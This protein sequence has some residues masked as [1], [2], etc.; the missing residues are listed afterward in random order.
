MVN[1]GVIVFDRESVENNGEKFA[2]ESEKEYYEMN[3]FLK[4]MLCCSIHGS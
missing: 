4:K 2:S 3:F 1:T